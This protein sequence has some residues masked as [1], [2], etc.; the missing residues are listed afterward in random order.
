VE[1]WRTS[2]SRHC[3]PRGFRKLLAAER[4]DI[5]TA[6]QSARAREQAFGIKYKGV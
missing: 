3:R 6:K 4:G 1:D 2:V 5:A